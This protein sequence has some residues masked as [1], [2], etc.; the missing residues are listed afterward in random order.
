MALPT[1]T[2]RAIC[3]ALAGAALALGGAAAFAQTVEE[4]TVIGKMGPEN[5]PMSL[6]YPVS[7][8]D[9]DLKTQ[10]GRDE[11]DRR[12]VVTAAYLCKKLGEEATHSPPVPT[13]RDQAVRDARP[14]AKRAS[15][16]AMARMTPW[17]AGPAW[18]P[19]EPQ[20]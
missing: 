4:L 11:L 2:S 3:G 10:S 19:P 12:I 5:K 7:F 13:C 6:S 15:E 16:E 8:R 20:Q 17:T 1:R 9:I 14:K 18:T